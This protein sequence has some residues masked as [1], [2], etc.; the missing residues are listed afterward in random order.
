LY[1]QVYDKAGNPIE[2]LLE[3]ANRDGIINDKDNCKV[4]WRYIIP[5]FRLG[6]CYPITE[7]YIP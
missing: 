1:H 5:L 2:G 3:D 4:F 7:F 6:I